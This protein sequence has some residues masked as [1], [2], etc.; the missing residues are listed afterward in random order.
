MEIN[1]DVVEKEVL[2]DLTECYRLSS[3]TENKEAIYDEHCT[4]LS[5]QKRGLSSHPES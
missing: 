5:F 4:W 2:R 3:L 1:K